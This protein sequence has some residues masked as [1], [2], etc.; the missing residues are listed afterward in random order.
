M[1][2]FSDGITDVLSDA[3]ILSILQSV[4][5]PMAERVKELVVESERLGGRD[6][7]TVVLVCE[8]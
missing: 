4:N 3:E 8:K 2:L 6:D 1:L 5:A 7:K